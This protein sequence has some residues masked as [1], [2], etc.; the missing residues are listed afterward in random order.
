VAANERR[1]PVVA[2]ETGIAGKVDVRAIMPI[3]VDGNFVGSIEFASTMDVP[4]ERAAETTELKWAVGIT[5]EV[6]QRVERPANPRVD[7]AQKDTIFYLFSDPQTAEL[8]H[9]IS[10]DPHA[11][12]YSL[13]TDRRHHTIFVRT[14][15]VIDFNGAPPS[16]SPRST[17]SAT[18]T[19]T[20]CTRS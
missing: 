14:F 8:M 10:F 1:Q 2:V 6:S 9:S 20:C 7:V 18:T 5:K 15:P 4:L 17:T 12:G 11:K 13:A 3:V 16:P 19:P